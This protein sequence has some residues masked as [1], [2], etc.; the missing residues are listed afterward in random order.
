MAVPGSSSPKLCPFQRGTQR[1]HLYMP[2]IFYPQG[3]IWCNLLKKCTCTQCWLQF[4]R[5]QDH[6][7]HKP[8]SLLIPLSCTQTRILVRNQKKIVLT[9]TVK[10]PTVTLSC[11]S[12]ISTSLICIPPTGNHVLSLSHETFPCPSCWWLALLH[13]SGP[14]SQSVLH[15]PISQIKKLSLNE[16]SFAQGFVACK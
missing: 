5:I 10:G 12:E 16:I 11:N 2:L 3:G 15:I 13:L 8:S 4:Q 14:R 7:P 1:R 9:E 6:S